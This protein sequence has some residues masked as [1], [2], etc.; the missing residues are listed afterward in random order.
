MAYSPGDKI[1]AKVK[2]HPHWPCRINPL[3]SGVHIPKGKYPIFFYGTHEVYFLGPRDIFPYEKYKEKYGISRNKAVFQAGLREI[4]E[5]PDVLLYG[6]DPNAEAFLARFY[7]FSSGEVNAPTPAPSSGKRSFISPTS[8]YNQPAKRAH[9]EAPSP[10]RKKQTPSTDGAKKSK[11]KNNVSAT[12]TAPAAVI[13]K[14]PSKRALKPKV[15]PPA[16]EIDQTPTTVTETP[17]R[18]Q[19][20]SALRLRIRKDAN[21]LNFCPASD[22][23]L[24]SLSPSTPSSVSTVE[25]HQPPVEAKPSS[26]T[27]PLRITIRQVSTATCEDAGSATFAHPV[28]SIASASNTTTTTTTTAS[29]LL[30]VG[31]DPIPSSKKTTAVVTPLRRDKALPV[32]SDD[33]SGL[34]SS[35]D[36]CNT[37]PE[38]SLITSPRRKEKQKTQRL[39]RVPSNADDCKQ[40]SKRKSRFREPLVNFSGGSGCSENGSNSTPSPWTSNE[41][42]KSNLTEV[43]GL[44]SLPL[45]ASPKSTKNKRVSLSSPYI[46]TQSP[47]CQGSDH[48]L[49]ESRQQQVQQ[50]KD[51]D[52]EARLLLIDRSIKSSLVRDHEDIPTCVDR[53]EMLDRISISLPVLAKCWTVVE[54]IGKCRRYK[55]S[56]EVKIAAQKV[57]NKFLQLYATADKSELDLAVATLARHQQRHIRQHTSGKT[58]ATGDSSTIPPYTGPKSMAELFQV[59]AGVLAERRRLG[60]ATTE[61]LESVRTFV[62]VSNKSTPRLG[63]TVSPVVSTSMINKLAERSSE[64]PRVAKQTTSIVDLDAWSA[65]LAVGEIP[66]PEEITSLN[67][68]SKPVNSEVDP[69]YTNTTTS[70]GNTEEEYEVLDEYEAANEHKFS[71]NQGSFGN[72]LSCSESDTSSTTLTSVDTSSR[73]YTPVSMVE[74]QI[75]PIS[76]VPPHLL[77]PPNSLLPPAYCPESSI[78]S[79]S[80]PLPSYSA[81]YPIVPTT[82]SYHSYGCLPNASFPQILPPVPPNLPPVPYT[83]SLGA[84]IFHPVF[85]ATPPQHSSRAYVPHSLH[86]SADPPPPYRP[87][88]PSMCDLDRSPSR[89]SLTFASHLPETDPTYTSTSSLFR[90]TS[91]NKPQHRSPSSPPSRFTSSGR[92]ED[93]GRYHR[94]NPHS[95]SRQFRSPPHRARSP[96]ALP[97]P[98]EHYQR[99]LASALTSDDD[100]VGSKH[101]GNYQKNNYKHFTGSRRSSDRGSEKQQPLS[102]SRTTEDLET[103]IARI[104]GA[105]SSIPTKSH[106]TDVKLNRSAITSDSRRSAHPLGSPPPPPP[107][108]PPT[109]QRILFTHRPPQS[110]SSHS[111]SKIPF[112]SNPPSHDS[113]TTDLPPPLTP[114]SPPPRHSFSAPRGDIS[115]PIDVRNSSKFYSHQSDVPSRQSSVDSINYRSDY[116]TNPN[117]PSRL[118][119][120]EGSCKPS[121]SAPNTDRHDRRTSR[122]EDRDLY[123]MLGV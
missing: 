41:W 54:T 11:K 114:D 109:S 2:G 68:V 106:S 110:V 99:C 117:G 67:R 52:T 35:T 20:V 40:N 60:Q 107:P 14:T 81:S 39:S 12:L 57:F 92:S 6:K 5:N 69:I 90:P 8:E 111:R 108:P 96:H 82:V 76:M 104:I 86:P 122:E 89:P 3:P 121:T 59:S 42:S 63:D 26:T 55:R 100:E 118:D 71:G 93:S 46:T 37:K 38:R 112:A 62:D 98:L 70:A 17:L 9:V 1:F 74:T 72:K 34:S 58:D 80:A 36:E 23:S 10:A 18:P 45:A 28:F 87:Y 53:L 13:S 25:H 123:S 97:H 77:P 105:A 30:G 120:P 79:G 21:G 103:R 33:S 29:T 24:S 19:R 113:D 119:A 31:N 84:P 32:L 7:K 101:S 115:Q 48:L 22:S 44:L 116:S 88:V 51:L 83:P 50:L 73:E 47:T 94:N 66:L 16:L 78:Y 91:V 15:K 85:E 27:D 102:V 61:Q 4:E 49:A 56:M 64:T 75:I 43:D 65:K 95:G